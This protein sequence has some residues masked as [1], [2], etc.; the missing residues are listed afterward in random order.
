MTGG[1]SP[2]AIMADGRVCRIGKELAGYDK[3]AEFPGI[4]KKDAQ[5]YINR[6]SFPE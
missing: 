5:F 3:R 2:I 1:T 4:A 6:R